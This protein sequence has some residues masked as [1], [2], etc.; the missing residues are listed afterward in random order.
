MGQ[1]AECHRPNS[2]SG[3][4]PNPVLPPKSGTARSDVCIGAYVRP[5]PT[6]PTAQ[7]VRDGLE[8]VRRPHQILGASSVRIQLVAVERFEAVKDV[9]PFTEVADHRNRI[10]GV[11]C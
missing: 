8:P 7:L 4:R 9:V 3:S 2:L 5:V 11:A 6:I 10:V 1:V